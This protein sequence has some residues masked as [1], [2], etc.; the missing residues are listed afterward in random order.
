ME[1]RLLDQEVLENNVR[2]RSR[3][4]D[5]RR[6][7]AYQRTFDERA[8]DLVEA[9]FDAVERDIR[10]DMARLGLRD[11]VLH[12]PKPVSALQ[13]AQEVKGTYIVLIPLANQ[14]RRHGPEHLGEDL[15]VLA[16]GVVPERLSGGLKRVCDGVVEFVARLVDVGDRCGAHEG[17]DG[18]V[19]IFAELGRDEAKVLW[20]R[21]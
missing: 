6:I 8:A 12:D 20:C 7:V 9:V 11:V 21:G 1:V 17:G 14:V 19:G 13:N 18:I 4:F 16:C 10:H 2:F 15:A 3:H 5:H